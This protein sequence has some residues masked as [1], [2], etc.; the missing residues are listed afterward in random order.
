MHTP[1]VRSL[2]RNSLWI[3]Q[4]S[5][6]I[7][8]SSSSDHI[9]TKNIW[10]PHE[11]SIRLSYS[12]ILKKAKQNFTS[13]IAYVDIVIDKSGMRS[14]LEDQV[15]LCVKRLEGAVGS[16]WVVSW[17]FPPLRLQCRWVGRYYGVCP[18]TQDGVTQPKVSL[19]QRPHNTNHF[20]SIGQDNSSFYHHHTNSS[21]THNWI[22]TR[23]H[24]TK[25]P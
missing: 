16:T 20:S 13:N 17:L 23:G 15:R 19:T 25:T 8:H 12:D 21:T 1:F 11:Y 10:L 2:Y 9:T 24:P 18:G 14:E 4:W 7:V 6:F 5:L 22:P 3:G